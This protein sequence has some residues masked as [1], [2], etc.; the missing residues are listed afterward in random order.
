[1]P[2]A[3]R[4]GLWARSR[5][6]E[7]GGQ[8]VAVLLEFGIGKVERY[9]RKLS[10]RHPDVRLVKRTLGPAPSLETVVFG[11]RLQG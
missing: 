5:A 9:I 6:R 3:R 8:T 1:M 7:N 4:W 11:P 2:M 10:E